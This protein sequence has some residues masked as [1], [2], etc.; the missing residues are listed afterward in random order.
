[1]SG[2]LQRQHIT[3]ASDIQHWQDRFRQ[4]NADV[5]AIYQQLEQV[6]ALSA[7]NPAVLEELGLSSSQVRDFMRRLTSA[8]ETTWISRAP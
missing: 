3:M 4:A 5:D 6:V 7:L 2:Y 1:M 8:C